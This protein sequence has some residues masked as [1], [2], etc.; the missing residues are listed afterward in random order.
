MNN[1]SYQDVPTVPAPLQTKAERRLE[2]KELSRGERKSGAFGVL[3]LVVLV[4]AAIGA[5]S[6]ESELMKDLA[7]GLLVCAGMGAL[8]LMLPRR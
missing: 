5:G 1:Y 7:A 8:S 2:P 4:V 3:A 6:M